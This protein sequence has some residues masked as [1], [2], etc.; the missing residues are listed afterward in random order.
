[1]P[2]LQS[3]PALPCWVPEKSFRHPRLRGPYAGP[4]AE[5]ASAWRVSFRCH[6]CRRTTFC[7]TRRQHSDSRKALGSV[8][9]GGKQFPCQSGT[10]FALHR[11][12]LRLPAVSPPHR[13]RVPGPRCVPR[14]IGGFVFCARRAQPG[15]TPGQFGCH[16]GDTPGRRSC[17]G[18]PGWERSDQVTGS[19]PN[20]SGSSSRFLRLGRTH[21]T[22]G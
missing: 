12:A 15:P 11:M 8:L 20:S 21:M 10:S 6:A 2:E 5:C 14:R 1:M 17:G 22:P 4:A 9:L 18:L 3:N 16:S 13:M 19:A 7:D